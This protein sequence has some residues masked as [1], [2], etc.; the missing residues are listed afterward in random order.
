MDTQFEKTLNA[1]VK[2]DSWDIQSALGA[3]NYLA[4][5][6][7]INMAVRLLPPNPPEASGV[8][9]FTAWEQKIKTGDIKEAVGPVLGYAERAQDVLNEYTTVSPFDY[10]H[11]LD[12]MTQRP[13]RQ[14]TFI[15]E[16]NQRKAMGMRPGVPMSVFVAEEYKLA[17][18]RHD[19]LV[20]VGQTAIHL[21][22]NMDGNDASAPDWFIEAV[23]A[24]VLQ[25]LEQ[26][27]QK[28]EMRRTNPRISKSQRD[29]AEANQKLIVQTIEELGGKKPDFSAEMAAE[30]EAMEDSSAW[31]DKMTAMSAANKAA[32]AAQKP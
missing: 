2:L 10:Q 4:L 14:E 9:G 7:A 27:W 12:F 29:E 3:V 25:K 28:N 16:Y 1:V 31:L 8:E 26:R 21:L 15:N 19:H 6:T 32:L 5:Q 17:M 11:V 13:P 23:E 18:Q 22:S 30:D 24:K 20:A